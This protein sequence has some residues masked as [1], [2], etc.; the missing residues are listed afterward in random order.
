MGPEKNPGLGSKLC[1]KP[2]TWG[3]TEKERLVKRGGTGTKCGNPVISTRNG[4]SKAEK[5][6]FTNSLPAPETD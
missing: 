2:K 1:D 6:P 3:Q 4:G 5:R